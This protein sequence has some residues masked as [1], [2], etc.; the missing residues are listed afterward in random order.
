MDAHYNKTKRVFSALLFGRSS[1][2]TESTND[3][4]S[5]STTTP[6]SSSNKPSTIHPESSSETL[7]IEPRTS[8]ITPD[9]PEPSIPRSSTKK[10]LETAA[11]STTMRPSTSSSTSG[12]APRAGVPSRFSTLLTLNFSRPQT[13]PIN[14]EPV[15]NCED[16]GIADESSI[17]KKESFGITDQPSQ[18]RVST[19]TACATLTRTSTTQ[20]PQI[21]DNQKREEQQQQ[22]QESSDQSKK[23]TN[24]LD[25]FKSVVV[26]A[27]EVAFMRMMKSLQSGSMLRITWNT[28]TG[29]PGSTCGGSGG[30]GL[31]SRPGSAISQRNI[32]TLDP[33]L[34]LP[35]ASEIKEEFR[36]VF[37]DLDYEVKL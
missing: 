19:A 22:Q 30:G 10:S 25:L 29:R 20:Q 6:P 23:Q 3:R 7:I 5:T 32:P 27:P 18:T 14:H 37:K 4:I 2:N 21:N 1:R 35:S 28:S 24:I 17:L 12:T 31:S 13:Q 8:G 33:G 9:S 15:T 34:Q 11:T 16:I 26:G 36:N